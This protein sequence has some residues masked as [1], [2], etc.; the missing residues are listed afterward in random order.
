MP[1]IK[2]KCYKIIIIII[3]MFFYAWHEISNVTIN[4]RTVKTFWVTFHK[5]RYFFA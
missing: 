5:T 3:I 1:N 4:I 2:K